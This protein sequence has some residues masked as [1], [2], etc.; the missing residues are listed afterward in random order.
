M[1]LTAG[2][3]LV[4]FDI[5]LKKI[6]SPDGNLTVELRSGAVNTS[7]A[8]THASNG[9]ILQTINVLSSSVSA[10]Q[11]VVTFTFNRNLTAGDYHFRI[12]HNG[13]LSGA[14][15]FQMDMGANVNDTR[16]QL[17]YSGSWVNTGTGNATQVI[18][19]NFDNTVFVAGDVTDY[20]YTNAKNIGLALSATEIVV[21]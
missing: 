7:V 16:A 11:A 12:Y 1:P 4:S 18:T 10:T 20:S 8:P 21:R 2:K 5:A 15:Y 17:Y 13:T 19:Y 9:T 6:G 3:K 14:N